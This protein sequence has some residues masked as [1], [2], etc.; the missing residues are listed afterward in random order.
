MSDETSVVAGRKPVRELLENDPGRVD[1]V[2]FRRG[3]DQ[4]MQHIID[5]CKRAG[6]HH[7]FVEP[8]ELERLSPGN[9]QGVVARVAGLTHV[10]LEQLLDQTR[11]A[12]LPLIVVL[13]QVQDPGNVGALARTLYALGAAGLVTA[14][15]EGAFLGPAAVRSSAGALLRLPVAKVTNISQALD[16][17]AE[18]GFSLVCARRSERAEDALRAEL[19]LPAAL[20]LGNEDKGVRPGVAKRCERDL[21]IPFGR[22]FDSLN[23][24][25]AGAIL[26]GL[27]ARAAGRTGS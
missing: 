22:E 3:R 2:Y 26:A 11:G 16:K 15:H 19:P 18:A 14:K 13:D 24:A 5:L 10:D 21:F 23:V 17:M 6:L 8:A 12:P 4:A 1:C 20:V 25:Q 27:W 9:H 7:R